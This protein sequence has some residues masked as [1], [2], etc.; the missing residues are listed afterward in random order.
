MLILFFCKY[1]CGILLFSSLP[2]FLRC[3]LNIQIFFCLKLAKNDKNQTCNATDIHTLTVYIF[4]MQ[5]LVNSAYGAMKIHTK[6]I[7]LFS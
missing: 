3:A 6:Q 2:R 5:R 1:D 4:T 7:P